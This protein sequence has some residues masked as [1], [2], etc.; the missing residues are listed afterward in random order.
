[1][2]AHKA[3]DTAYNSGNSGTVKKSTHVLRRRHNANKF[4]FALDL[5]VM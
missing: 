3:Y 2:K 4:A 5:F 1:M